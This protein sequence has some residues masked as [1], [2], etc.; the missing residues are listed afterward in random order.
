MFDLMQKVGK[1]LFVFCWLCLSV[2]FKLKSV[3]RKKKINHT[4][5]DW[6]GIWSTRRI[7][8]ESSGKQQPQLLASA[9]SKPNSHAMGK[10]R[11]DLVHPYKHTQQY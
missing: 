4:A 3:I 8:T 6:K 9:Q 7:L 5:A 2:C 11:W 1:F 10:N